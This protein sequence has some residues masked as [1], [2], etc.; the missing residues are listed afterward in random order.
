MNHLMERGAAPPGVR[1][2]RKHASRQ[3]RFERPLYSL[4]RRDIR[5]LGVPGHY[6]EMS[7]GSGLL[8]AML[9][10]DPNVLTVTAVDASADDVAVA[11]EYLSQRGLQG[12]VRCLVGDVHDQD[13]MRRLGTF[14]VVY[15]TLALHHWANPA[16][17]VANLWAALGEGGALYIC[18]FRRVWWARFLHV[19]NKGIHYQN[20]LTSTELTIL[21][22]QGIGNFIIRKRLSFLQSITAWKQPAT[23]EEDRPKKCDS[24]ASRPRPFSFETSPTPSASVSTPPAC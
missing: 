3:R 10:E 12:R 11:N 9:A 22:T 2:A 7:A 15:S 21:G 20:S 6:L 4:F 1:Q 16:A 13:F 19:G 5:A 18:D 23:W 14:D 24:E 17:A 8:A